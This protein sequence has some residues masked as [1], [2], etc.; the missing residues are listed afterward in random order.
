M[1]KGMIGLYQQSFFIMLQCTGNI[2]LHV[3]THSQIIVRGGEIG[4]PL[5][6]VAQT[7]NRF[8]NPFLPTRDQSNHLE[9]FDTFGILG[10]NL[11]SQIN[12]LL[13]LILIEELF[14]LP[15]QSEP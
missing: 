2:S 5:Q 4:S 10:Q 7:F 14:S 15:G 6:N 8:L 11:L 12:S 9:R 1:R 3:V 13:K